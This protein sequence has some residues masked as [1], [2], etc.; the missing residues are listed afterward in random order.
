M[1]ATLIYN[2]AGDQKDSN[3]PAKQLTAWEE[4]IGRTLCGVEDFDEEV[5]LLFAPQTEEVEPIFAIIKAYQKCCDASAVELQTNHLLNMIPYA[6]ELLRAKIV[7]QE[8]YDWSRR[9]STRLN[10][11]A[12]AKWEQE[13]YAALKQKLEGKSKP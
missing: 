9:F 3:R 5:V 12:H 7:T 2:G 13:T 8:E 6:Y 1:F 10:H 11:E 4:C